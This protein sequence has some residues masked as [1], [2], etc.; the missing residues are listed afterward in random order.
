[1][2]IVLFVF[3]LVG[4]RLIPMAIGRVFGNK[5]KQ[6]LEKVATALDRN[7]EAVTQLTQ[8]VQEM[9]NG[10]G[11]PGPLANGDSPAV[12]APE[13]VAELRHT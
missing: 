8:L 2:V 6:L 9:R 1:M 7:T 4:I 3:L 11:Q 10:Y 13:D 5:D 12:P